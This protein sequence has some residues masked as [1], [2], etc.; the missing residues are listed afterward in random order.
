M[1]ASALLSDRLRELL[2]VE[3]GACQTCGS[4]KITC[5]AIAARVGLSH[6]TVWRFMS[7]RAP[8][9]HTID[10]L[11]ARYKDKLR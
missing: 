11:Y 4:A 1:S 7:G 10:V 8:N 2:K 6:A 3:A 5:R 9:A